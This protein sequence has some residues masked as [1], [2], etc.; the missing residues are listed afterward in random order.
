M[1]NEKIWQYLKIYIPIIFGFI[2]IT[3]IYLNIDANKV[4]NIINNGNFYLML[5]GLLLAV[6]ANICSS[7]RW[8]IIANTFGYKNLTNKNA[9]KLYF[10]GVMLNSIFPGG[11][12]GGDAWRIM[13]LKKLQPDKKIITGTV[14]IFVDRISGLW[15]L[16]IL[17]VIFALTLLPT[18]YNMK[19]YRLIAIFIILIS[20]LPVLFLLPGFDRCIPIKLNNIRCIAIIAIR[21]TIIF[22]FISNILVISALFMCLLSV[23]VVI[24]YN[25]VGFLSAGIFLPA[26]IPASIGGFGVREVSM[27]TFLYPLIPN[28]EALI[29]G[30]LVFGTLAVCQGVI[31]LLSS[32][33]N[34][35]FLYYNNEI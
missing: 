25:W 14:T 33:A 5:I 32:I 16:L 19:N 3:L 1:K 4:I 24:A 23:D 10:H 11:F 34:R 30:S 27:I 29:A 21:K 20:F 17:S 9:V 7:L 8:C 35:I 22:S 12:I 26:L 28:K 15:S 18:I 13:N 6:M 2:L 31:V